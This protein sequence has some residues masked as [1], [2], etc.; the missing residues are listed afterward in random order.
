MSEA[1]RASGDVTSSKSKPVTAAEEN[2]GVRARNISIG[3]TIR[4]RSEPFVAVAEATFDVRPSEMVCIV[5]P[6]GCGKSTVLSAVAGLMPVRSGSLAVNG[7]PVTGPAADRAVVFQKASLLPWMTVED[8]AAYGLRSYGTAK[9]VARERAHEL[10]AI[11]GLSNFAKSYPYQ[12]SGGMQ[13]RTN[14]ARAL[15]ADPKLLLFDEPFASLDAQ[16]REMLQAE[17]M[18]IWA[19]TDKAGLFITHQIDEA[20]LL[21]NRVL[22]STKGPASHITNAIE[23]D[24]PWPRTRN[25]RLHPDFNGYVEHIWSLLAAEQV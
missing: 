24:L 4:G 11:V 12:L 23:I 19:D 9:S 1:E 7:R 18:R 16:Q 10:L 6:S 20:V 15:A 2:F 14:L 13:Q 22:V 8:N 3:Y 21:G 17:L 25:T 5:G